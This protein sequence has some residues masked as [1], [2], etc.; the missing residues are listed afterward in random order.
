MRQELLEAIEQVGRPEEASKSAIEELLILRT[1]EESGPPV[2]ISGA[3]RL[4]STK[5]P[6]LARQT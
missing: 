5:W 4:T 1:T 2:R 3:I 6:S